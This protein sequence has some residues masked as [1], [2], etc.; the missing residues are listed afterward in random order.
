MSRSDHGFTLVEL[1]I[2]M[3]LIGILS[4]TIPNFIAN[5]LQASSLAQQ[6]TAL[7]SNAENALDT[8]NQDIRLSGAAD[9]NNRWADPNAPGAPADQLSWQST[10]NV[11]V[12][13]KAA[14]DSSKNIIFSDPAKYI[15]QKDNEIYYVSGGTLYRRT[16]KSS[17][18][19]DA[20]VTTCPPAVATAGCPAD[21][22]IAT[23]VTAF[24]VKYYDADENQVIPSDARSI[25]LAIT[26]QDKSGYKTISASYTTRMVFRNE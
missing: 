14:A 20:T 16:I 10:S 12:L 4:L 24:S 9:D 26:M 2:V 5:W 11:L 6:R 8:V 23:G 18:A 3:V 15:S 22:T 13:A 21:K 7:L 17:D 1:M 25:Q 19:T